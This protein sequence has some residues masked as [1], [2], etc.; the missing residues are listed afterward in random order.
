MHTA[1]LQKY[2]FVASIV[3]ACPAGM[4][5]RDWRFYRS[6]PK[7]LLTQE[8]LWSFRV[9][10]INK[11]T[12][13]SELKIKFKSTSISILICWQKIYG[14]L[15]MYILHLCTCDTKFLVSE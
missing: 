5:L 7:H 9:N 4:D 2:T 1:E 10:F 13:V 8:N 14:I 12:V 11:Y 15:K 6:M 3:L